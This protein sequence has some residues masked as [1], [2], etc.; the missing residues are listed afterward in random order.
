[1][2]SGNGFK[3]SASVQAQEPINMSKSKQYSHDDRELTRLGKK[4]VLARNFSF[5]TILGFSCTLLSTWEGTLVLF[6]QGY[7]N[8]G[9]SG[10]IYGYI[11]AWI[12]TVSLFITLSELVSMAPTSAGQYHWVYMLAPPKS[13]QFLSY[14][15]G[16]I[17]VT[18]WQGVVASAAY[19]TGTLIQGLILLT[20]P[21]YLASM[22]S[23]HGTLLFW[24]VVLV[25]FVINSS[26]GTTLARFEGTVLILHILGFFAV[27]LSIVLLGT[28]GPSASVFDTWLNLGG[29]ETQGLSFSIG[30]LGNVF[31]FLGADGAIHMSEEIRDA[32]VILPRSLIAGIAINGALGFGMLIVVLFFVGDIDAALAANPLY[33]FMS[34]FQQN[35]GSTAGA[36]VLSAVIIVLA[37]S[38]TTGGLA[39]CSRIYWAFSRDRGLP[40]WRFLKTVNPKTRIPFNSVIV[41]AILSIILSLVNIGGAAAF[42]G[43]VSITISGLFGSY[44]IACSLLLYRRMTGAMGTRS[45]TDDIASVDPTK[46]TWGPWRVRGW[47][48]IAN[49]A[50][51]CAFLT[52]A[53]FFSFWPTY[54]AVTPAN[55]NYVVLVT[56]VVL[57][58]SVVYYA[59]HARRVFTGPVVESAE[60]VLQDYTRSDTPAAHSEQRGSTAS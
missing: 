40:G 1:M 39:S 26:V 19:L 6:L 14:I 23:W 4:P 53:L 50:F 28:P 47:L 11:V 35:L 12:G 2:S 17:A 54:K 21:S 24:A 31:S 34:I 30:I 42:T 3:P 29:W 51:T 43:V 41:A 45:D 57:V 27:L 44:L 37:F 9:P 15:T 38:A 52:Y 33:P 13:K 49:N 60:T 25:S 16:W 8:G 18:G 58:F 56:G 5:L 22:K 55:F 46:P 32:A 36:A 7:L 20:H 48:G 59:V 10:L